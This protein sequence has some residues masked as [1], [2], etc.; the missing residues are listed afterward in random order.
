[1]S[2][3]ALE[4]FITTHIGVKSTTEVNNEGSQKNEIIVR[5]FNTHTHTNID[6]LAL[7]E[8]IQQPVFAF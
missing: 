5:G 1:M 4:L 6:A 7:A 2:K 8:L 3:H